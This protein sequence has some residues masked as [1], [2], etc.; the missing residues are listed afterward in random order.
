MRKYNLIIYILFYMHMDHTL[1]TNV[2]AKI[3]S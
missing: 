2:Y 1:S 3:Y